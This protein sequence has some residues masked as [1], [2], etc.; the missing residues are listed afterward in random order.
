MKA[1]LRIA[2]KQD[3][4]TYY[5]VQGNVVV[6]QTSP[7][8]LE[9]DPDG[10]RDTEVSWVR[11][12][13]VHGIVKPVTTPYKFPLEGQ[14]ILKHVFDTYHI[15]GRCLMY[16]EQLDSTSQEYVFFYQGVI[17]LS[18]YQND[19]VYVTAVSEEEGL[20]EL[21]TAYKDIEQ[22][23]EVGTD[24]ESVLMDG[25]KLKST[26]EWIAGYDGAYT[27]A[28]LA[29]VQ[30]YIPMASSVADPSAYFQ[31]Y[32]FPTDQVMHFGTTD[33]TKR[34]LQLLIIPFDAEIKIEFDIDWTA[35][36][37]MQDVQLAILLEQVDIDTLAQTDIYTFLSTN[38]ATNGQTLN[39]ASSVVFNHTIMANHVVKLHVNVTNNDTTGGQTCSFKVNRLKVT[40]N[41]SSK[42]PTSTTK[43]YRIATL[44]DKLVKKMA[45]NAYNGQAPFFLGTTYDYT[46]VYY[47]DLSPFH[48]IATPSS[49][50]RKLP[51]Q[52]FVTSLWNCYK[53]LAT[54]FPLGIGISGN[55]L[56]LDRFT[57]FYDANIL[58]KDLGIV[59]KFKEYPLPGF[60]YNELRIG[61]SEETYDKVNGL[62]EWNT[63]TTYKLNMPNAKNVKEMISPFKRDMYGI[64]K[65]RA[66]L[67]G[68]ITTD[69]E[70]D[71]DIFLLEVAN[72][73][74]G[75]IYNEGWLLHRPQ[76]ETS[77]YNNNNPYVTG[78]AFPDT[79]FNLGFTA[80]K[81]ALRNRMLLKAN[82]Y[83]MTGQ[84]I[85]F[86]TKE[87]NRDIITSLYTYTD[88]DVSIDID[89][90]PN[91]PFAPV[92]YEF[93]C[94]VE[95]NMNTLLAGNQYGYFKFETEGGQ[96]LEGWIFD[97][98]AS[99][100]NE[101]P[102]QFKLIKKI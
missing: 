25:V 37:V 20:K 15:T 40:M 18:M 9:N 83:K 67:N 50:L 70:R 89:T 55:N 7:Y 16:V 57:R 6:T 78:V 47:N 76:N 8:F 65:V 87:K 3:N 45:G 35:I 26:Y 34:M 58:I 71:K 91:P 56:I 59:T 69:E 60:H 98:T 12:L 14:M 41:G 99:A 100:S 49:A 42:L 64:E 90:L 92:V 32:M 74:G 54:S 102:V 17:D 1:P 68:K 24:A 4:T 2:L 94:N 72:S 23:I 75:T 62:D 39:W 48:I 66:D 93:E 36:S 63:P 77:I 29:N 86:K 53:S 38:A 79:A 96:Q 13:E 19:E 31:N 61:N 21:Y 10:C 81:D 80:K 33:V 11:N 82:A 30:T 22:E 51:K 5:A 43:G 44:W 27:Q 85:E 28:A 84:V 73:Y 52:R 95:E 97:V 46:A 101:K 88:E